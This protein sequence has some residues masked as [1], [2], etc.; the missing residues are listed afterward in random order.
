MREQ[1]L[2]DE[3]RRDSAHGAVELPPPPLSDHGAASYQTAFDPSAG[4]SGGGPRVGYTVSSPST[5]APAQ[6]EANASRYGGSLG[7]ALQTQAKAY[8]LVPG[9]DAQITGA[10][11]PE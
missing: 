10:I 6:A 7:S 4:G 2:N 11:Q 1:P 5:V 9:T 3:A 8:R